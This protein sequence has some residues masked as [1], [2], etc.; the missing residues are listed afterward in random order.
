MYINM[1][2]WPLLNVI[3][4]SGI[5]MNL[6]ML[7]LYFYSYI[8]VKRAR[9]EYMKKVCIIMM[10]FNIASVTVFLS[11][12]A[13]AL[14]PQMYPPELN[15][16]TYTGSAPIVSSLKLI[17]ILSSNGNGRDRAFHFIY[18]CSANLWVA[19]S[20]TVASCAGTGRLL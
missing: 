3:L 15:E 20:E 6:I 14:S 2:A 8:R 12:Y 1:K 10:C 13:I 16:T 5:A 7:C 18:L 9:M 19:Q 17:T 4:L 11:D